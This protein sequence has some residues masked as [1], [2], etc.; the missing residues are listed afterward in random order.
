MVAYKGRL[1]MIALPIILFLAILLIKLRMDFAK[2]VNNK[3]VNHRA[4]FVLF[5]L[6]WALIPGSL[7]VWLSDFSLWFSI[8]V[9]LSMMIFWV[10]LVFDGLYNVMRKNYAI[11]Q[12]WKL[13]NGMYS[14]FYTGSNDKDDSVS[15]NLLQGLKQW[16]HITIKISGVI[17]F[18]SIYFELWKYF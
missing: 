4:E 12:G 13:P 1:Y 9:T 8:P 5:G 17:L 11:E 18:S 14:F 7:F 2:W 16:Q 3:P 15:D 6:A 10:W